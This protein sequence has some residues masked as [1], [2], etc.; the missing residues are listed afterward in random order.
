MKWQSWPVE[1]DV[2]IQ[3][4]AGELP[5][6]AD[7]QQRIDALWRAE[8]EAHPSRFDG[9]LLVLVDRDGE[10]LSG[11]FVPYRYFLAQQRDPELARRLS[12]VPIGVSGLLLCAD[13]VAF[14]RRAADV[15][16]YPGYL[17]LM[18]SGGINDGHL[19]E[20]GSVD[21]RRQLMEELVEEAGVDPRSVRRI[22][23][24]AIVRN[25]DDGDLDVGAVI[26][27]EPAA[28]GAVEERL[29]RP[30]EYRELRWTPRQELGA[31]VR[32]QAQS[33]VP[34]SIA[35]VEAFLNHAGI[36]ATGRP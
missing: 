5:V 34:T 28:R 30:G 18:P 3:T 13:V 4:M 6:D 25:Y 8:L 31:F 19:K 24:L 10:R 29:A 12:L 20:D 32:E 17:E 15:T 36:R 35:L 7:V 27:L 14:A 22:D 11:R 16:Q 23:P 26:E 9:R 1:T 2:Q 33:L 21:Y